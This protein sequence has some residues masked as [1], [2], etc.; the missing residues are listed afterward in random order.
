[1]KDDRLVAE[2]PEIDVPAVKRKPQARPDRIARHAR[3]AG[4]CDT[5]KMVDDFGNEAPSGVAM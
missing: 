3:M 4:L 2:N 1:M 5:M